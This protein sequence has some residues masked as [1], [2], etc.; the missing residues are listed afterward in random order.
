M[1]VIACNSASSV[2]QETVRKRAGTRCLV[3]DVIQPVVDK[4]SSMKK[5][6][7]IGV[8][9]TRATI[10]SRAYQ[11]GIHKKNPGLT[12]SAMATPLLAPMIEEG[13]FDNKISRTIINNYLS[14]SKLN[15]IEALILA[16]THYPLIKKEIGEFYKD[17]IKIVDTAEI[18]ARFVHASLSRK[19]ILSTRKKSGNNKFYVSDLTSSFEKSTRI[20]FK[21][22]IHL[23]HKNLWK[24]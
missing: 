20:F 16:C 15:R 5:L 10:K 4:I 22:K 21:G 13:F 18:V 9:G 6:S 12:V 8:I 11:E 23:E 3:V 7:H 2:A 14:S 17:E 19:K 1:I 24:Q